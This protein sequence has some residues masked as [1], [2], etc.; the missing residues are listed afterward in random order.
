MTLA[1]WLLLAL[2]GAAIIAYLVWWYR[3]RE[4]PV[5]GR[6]WALAM[7]GAALILAWLILL[8]PSFPRVWDP[9]AATTATLLDASLSMSRPSADG[10][11]ALWQVARDS[12]HLA[13]GAW[14]FGGPVPRYVIG[15]SLPATATAP[16]TR[17]TPAIR[18]AA[19]S[20]ASRAVV[21]TD[22]AIS[23]LQESLREAR[24]LGLALEFVTLAPDYPSFGISDLRTSGWVQSGDSAEVTVDIVASRAG[25]DSVRVEVVDDLD[26]VRASGWVPVPES[27]RFSSLSLSFPVMGAPGDRHFAARIAGPTGD[28][29]LGDDWRAFY[30][31][32]TEQPMGPVLI[33]LR[34]DWE[35]SFLISNLDR[36]TD[37][38]TAAYLWLAN[39]LVALDNYRPV[40]LPTVRRS[41]RDAPLLVLHGFGSDAPDW[42]RTLAQEADRLLVFPAGDRPFD[43]PGWNVRVQAPNSGEW[44]ASEAVPQ[45]PLALELAGLSV[46]ALPPLLRVRPILGQAAWSPLTVRRSRRGEE[47]P[48]VVV[49]QRRGRRWAVASAEGYWRWAF[50]PGA[51][52]QL[53][54]SLWT[55]LA[56]WLME[57]RGGGDF[58]LGPREKVVALGEPLRWVAPP[59]VDS[60]T[61]EMRSDTAGG[62][63]GVVLQEAI[64]PADSF[65]A[66]L[67]PGRYEYSVRAFR[68]GRA[69]AAATGTVE[70]ERFSPEL[71]PSAPATLVGQGGQAGAAGVG[72]SE[73]TASPADSPAGERRLA[74]LGWPYLLLIMLFCAE[75]I[76]R[77]RIGL[78]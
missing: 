42:A 51:G 29:E 44:Y 5:A 48:A 76:I 6:A 8:N 52:R 66:F 19:L 63:G 7:R 49:G 61:L 13:E 67:P 39:G 64:A 47:T 71:L 15:D 24:R 31:R 60:V 46:D 22:G 40:S 54:R 36:V 69:A 20:G 23:D 3:T 75:W 53:Y 70:V 35:P 57:G 43:I 41:A 27:G 11:P 2:G 77:R 45:S 33:S 68:S 17:L 12:A 38:P 25:V 72:S 65:E 59:S 55:G 10:G 62:G 56:G 9:N 4:E 34:P 28:L 32:V 78:R 37:A 16:E 73:A 30:I 21:Y 1:K 26:R 58:G 18:A 74:T 50:R 14:L